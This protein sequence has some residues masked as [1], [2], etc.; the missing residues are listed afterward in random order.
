MGIRGVNGRGED[1]C[2]FCLTG[3]NT[4][5]Q[6]LTSSKLVSCDFLLAFYT[7]GLYPSLSRVITNDDLIYPFSY[8]L[9]IS[10]FLLS[11]KLLRLL[12]FFHFLSLRGDHHGCMSMEF[13]LHL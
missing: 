3:S 9:F 12:A 7:P 1:C 10:F 11:W 8:T 2:N 13:P 5:F 6:C 4:C